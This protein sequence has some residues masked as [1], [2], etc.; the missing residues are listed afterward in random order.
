MVV[1]AE[2]TG[3]FLKALQCTKLDN[4]KRVL[5]EAVE[6][7][8]TK[9]AA[10]TLRID[11]NAT[12]VTEM[13][14]SVIASCVHEYRYMTGNLNA[15]K[16]QIHNLL[17]LLVFAT[18][19]SAS[20]TYRERLNREI[21]VMCQEAIEEDKTKREK[22]STKLYTSGKLERADDVLAMIANW[23]TVHSLIVKDID[24]SEIWKSLAEYEVTVHR[25]PGR[26]LFERHSSN[27]Q[28]AL[29]MAVGCQDIVDPY[30]LIGIVQEYREA[31]R[32]CNH[33]HHAPY[34]QAQS[35]GKHVCQELFM[36]IGR[37]EFKSYLSIL[38]VASKLPHL[39]LAV[40]V[41][42][43]VCTPWCD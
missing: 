2:L 27:T 32:T 23:C 21:K 20:V 33:V 10:S 25:P 15:E 39:G 17:S 43:L 36:A 28:G 22:K 8:G 14:D 6:G 31:L 34:F 7:A 35:V 1:P 41:M 16:D 37:N 12:L 13:M 19:S 30:F 40:E 9:V 11:S 29:N 38:L 4:F 5:M 3:N 42:P 18:P 26:K 24:D